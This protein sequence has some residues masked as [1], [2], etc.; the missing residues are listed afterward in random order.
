MKSQIGRCSLR[1]ILFCR[2]VDLSSSCGSGAR[3]QRVGYQRWISDGKLCQKTECRLGPLLM[4]VGQVPLLNRPS[5]SSPGFT[6][7]ILSINST[8]ANDV[9]L[10]WKVVAAV[11]DLSNPRI[12]HL[13]FVYFKLVRFA[14]S[15]VSSL[16]S[17][18]K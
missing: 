4:A 11:H 3:V 12:D 5:G 16:L 7:M 9:E 13:I 8:R 2:Q 15:A 18:R 17:G 10:V 6:E 14:A 1:V